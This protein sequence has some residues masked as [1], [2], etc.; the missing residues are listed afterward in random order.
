MLDVENLDGRPVKSQKDVLI[1]STTPTRA[2]D[3]LDYLSCGYLN[4]NT[5]MSGVE[6][7]PQKGDTM[8]TLDGQQ[9]LSN[10]IVHFYGLNSI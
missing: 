7:L 3:I 9:P 1:L 4:A 10:D 8:V 2:P 5:V 6:L